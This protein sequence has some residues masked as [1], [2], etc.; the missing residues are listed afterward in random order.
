MVLGDAALWTSL[1]QTVDTRLLQR[2]SHVWPTIQNVLGEQQH[3]LFTS[4][5]NGSI[6]GNYLTTL[7]NSL[8][9]DVEMFEM[10]GFD[11]KRHNHIC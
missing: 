4:G 10:L 11:L 9:E 6:V 8:E 2:M 1:F 5:A 7:G 3:R